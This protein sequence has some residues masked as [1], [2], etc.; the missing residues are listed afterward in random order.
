MELKFDVTGMTCAACSAR[1][2]KVTGQIPGVI[3]A[4]VNLLAGK[5]V[6][7]AE[8]HLIA[9]TIIEAVKKAGYGANL[10]GQKKQENKPLADTQIRQMKIRLISSFAFMLILMYF[11]MGHMIGLPLPAWYHGRENA[12][13]AA[14]LQLC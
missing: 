1:V 13:V 8:N 14:L 5:M 11:T 2:E 12:V 10:S 7:E 9:D 3:K 6:V 4:E